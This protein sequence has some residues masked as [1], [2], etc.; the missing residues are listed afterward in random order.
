[1]I[2]SQPLNPLNVWLARRC[3]RIL[4]W[5]GWGHDVHRHA[6]GRWLSRWRR[7]GEHP[8]DFCMRCGRPNVVWFAQSA[9]WNRA[10]PYGGILCPVCFIQ[11]AET[12]GIKP[13]AW[14]VRPEI[15]CP[16]TKGGMDLEL[17][18]RFHCC[19]DCGRDYFGSVLYHQCTR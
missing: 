2:V 8:E 9:I 16:E 4:Y 17:D 11:A 7:P 6:N 12:A 18:T 14:E 1:M 13:T 19:P 15:L 3:I 10:V 5:L